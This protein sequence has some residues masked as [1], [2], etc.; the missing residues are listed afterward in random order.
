MTTL[1]ELI[2]NWEAKASTPLTES[3]FRVRLARKDAAKIAALADMYPGRTQEQIIT[4]LLG[5]ALTELETTL[6]YIQGDR[7][8]AFDE[9]GDPIYEDVGPT[10]QFAKLVRK[11]LDDSCQH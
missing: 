7:I 4:E 8:S 3:E 9:L 2:E 11:H 1:R 6:P 10:A 5:A